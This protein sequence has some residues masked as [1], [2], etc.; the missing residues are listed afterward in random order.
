ML[1]HHILKKEQLNVRMGGNIGKSFAQQVAED[2]AGYEVLELSSFQ[3]DGIVSFRP[4][5]AIITN[6][7]PDHL[8]RY[9]YKFENY[10]NSKFRITKNQKETDYLI[11]DKE[12]KVISNWLRNNKVKAKLLPF[13][14][15]KELE[16]G[17]FIRD[18]N[19]IIKY[20]N[21]QQNSY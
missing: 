9:N 2:K 8:D 21:N 18:N 7:T 19:I 16:D 10:I 12:D 13:S 17:A 1:V 20:N 3:L 11:Y 4:N 6:I 15:E 14:T 5:I